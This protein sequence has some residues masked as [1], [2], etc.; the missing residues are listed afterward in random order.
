M[1]QQKTNPELPSIPSLSSDQ[2]HRLLCADYLESIA[3]LIRQGR[4]T[5]FDLAWDMSAEEPVGKVVVESDTFVSPL[6]QRLLRDIAEAQAAAAR[7][8]QVIDA[9]EHQK[10]ENPAC[11]ACNNPNKA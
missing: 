9:T 7:Q 11:V 1:S 10:C 6:K 4:V 5:G 2:L 8:I 3:K